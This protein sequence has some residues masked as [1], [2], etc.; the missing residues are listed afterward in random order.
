MDRSADRRL[1]GLFLAAFFACPLMA[2]DSRPGAD[3]RPQYAFGTD[4]AFDAAS[5]P[6]YRGDHRAIHARIDQDLPEH[7]DHLRR[8][9]RQRSIS[10]Q[11]DGVREMA[12]LLAG[13]LRALGFGE[14]ALVETD[15]HPGVFG[16]YDAGAEKTL[17]VYMMYDVQPVEEN[18]RIADPFAGDLVETELGTV[19]MARGA[20]NEK[21]PQRAF[22][23]ALDAILK[24]E[25]TLPV[26]LLVVPEGEEE[27]GSTHFGQ[28]VA[29]YLERL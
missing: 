20:T 28:V 27:L 16:H 12:E 6:T 17:M 8:W 1:V 15:G 11:D 5:I 23:N 10:A 2:A 25:G 29:P 18:W 7:I 14:V 9:L 21:G 4:E 13:D 19:L 22:L 3:P 24:V 26:N